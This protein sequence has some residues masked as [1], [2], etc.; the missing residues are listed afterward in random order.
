MSNLLLRL[1]MWTVVEESLKIMVCVGLIKFNS[2]FKYILLA[3]PVGV[4]LL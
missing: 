2:F 3:T 4:S 1:K